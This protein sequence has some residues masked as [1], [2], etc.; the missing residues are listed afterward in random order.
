MERR[1]RASKTGTLRGL[2]LVEAVL[3]LGLAILLSS[4]AAGVRD[5]S[6][7]DIGADAGVRFVAAGAFVV[8]VLA[9]FASRGVRR[10]RPW[11]WTLSALMQLILALGTGIAVLAAEWH[12]G[13]LAVFLLAGLVMVVL[14]TAS[15]R[16]ALGQ[17]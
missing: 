10:R 9:A 17:E 2:L 13:Y 16:R 15:V 3:G 5:L 6:P 14:S 4:V 11:S 8:A 1:K 12:P 7:D